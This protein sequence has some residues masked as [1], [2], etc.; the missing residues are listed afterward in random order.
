MLSRVQITAN[1]ENL[2]N[3]CIPTG[4]LKKEYSKHADAA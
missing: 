2:K 3:M 4:K 1:K